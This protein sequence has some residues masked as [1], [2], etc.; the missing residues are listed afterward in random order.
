MG[1]TIWPD[2]PSGDAV[3]EIYMERIRQEQ[4]RI[5]GR[6]KHTC[7]ANELTNPEKLAILGEE[8]GEACRAVVELGNLCN[9]KHKVN[10]RKELVQIAAV[11]VAWIESLS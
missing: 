8:F 9:D 2:G 4:L 10:L 11:C 7:A 1:Y 6:F 5:E 3:S